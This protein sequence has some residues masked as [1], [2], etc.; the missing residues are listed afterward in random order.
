MTEQEIKATIIKAMDDNVSDDVAKA[1]F[2]GVL[3]HVAHNL[4]RIATALE[5]VAL[6]HIEQ[7][8]RAAAAKG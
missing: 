7:A 3:A 6:A 4:E 5:G 2:A 1:A 8:E